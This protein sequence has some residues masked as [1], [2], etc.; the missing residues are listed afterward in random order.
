MGRFLDDVAA[1]T[2]P[3][4]SFVEPD[5]GYGAGDG[6]SQH[7]GNNTVKGDSFLAGERL[8]ARIY[9]ALA[10]NPALFAKTLFLVT[11]DEHGG[12]FDHG[13]LHRVVPPDDH[14]DRS[15]FDFSWSGVRVPAVAVSPLIPAGTVDAT[16][17][18][19]ASIPAT[20]RKQFAPGTPPLT[21]RDAEAND[22]LDHLPLLPEPRTDLPAVHPA[23]AAA[24]P[25]R[26]PDK[27]LNEF[28]ASLVELA[29]AVR[30]AREG[31]A[32]AAAEPRLARPSDAAPGAEPIPEFRPDPVTHEA[33]V[34]RRLPPD[35]AA[36]R[37]VDDVVA[38]FVED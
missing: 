13:P 4:Y 23:S 6:N 1:G 34:S 24:A 28:Q 31:R 32:A 33:A 11:Y 7:P 29:G 8:M 16:F 26:D 38:D 19:H 22:L 25:R 3:A 36:D 2:L 20:V 17:Y 18:D 9:D 27:R 10:A 21:R 12:F 30:Q 5:H 14:L 37:A 35:S 15:G